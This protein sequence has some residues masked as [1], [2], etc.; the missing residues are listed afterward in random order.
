MSLND[1]VNFPVTI[2]LFCPTSILKD[3]WV[4]AEVAVPRGL[5]KDLSKGYLSSSADLGN[6]LAR[7]HLPPSPLVGSLLRSANQLGMVLF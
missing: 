1:V 6:R 7:S 3:D 2:R 5:V 4:T